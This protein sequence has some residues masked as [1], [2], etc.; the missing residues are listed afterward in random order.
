LFDLIDRD[1]EI[2]VFLSREVSVDRS[3]TDARTA[4]DLV[5]GDVKAV[6]CEQFLRGLKH[7]IAIAARVGPH[8]TIR[9]LVL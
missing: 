8:L 9:I 2:E 7:P 4:S 3:G 1:G 5:E 6:P